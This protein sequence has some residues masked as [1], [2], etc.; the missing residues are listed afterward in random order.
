MR[1]QHSVGLLAAVLLAFGCDSGPRA[2]T[3]TAE[4]RAALPAA[5]EL[6]SDQKDGHDRRDR[7]DGPTVE[8]LRRATARFREVGNAEGAGYGLFGGCFSDPVQGGMGIHY[9]NGALMA[10]STVDALHPEAMVY[11]RLPSGRLRLN[12]VEYIVF[13]DEW[14]AKGHGGPPRLFGQDF[15]INPTLLAKPFYLLHVW[16]WLENPSGIF[17]DWNP[18]V[19][20]R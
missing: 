6:H 8:Q 18:R 12:A 15:H 20:C 3:P 11:E 5:A 14:H 19:Q 13:V 1:T 2:E 7:R 4:S 16:A 10:D 17:N 9:V